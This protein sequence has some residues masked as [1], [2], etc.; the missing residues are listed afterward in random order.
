MM[1]FE[2]QNRP[3]REQHKNEFWT[4]S[5]SEVNITN[6][7]EKVDQKNGVICLVSMLSS[8]VMVLKLSKK[9]LFCNFMLTSAR[10]LSWLKQFTYMHLKGLVTHFQKLM[11]FIMLWLTVSVVWVFEVVEFLRNFWWVSIFF[12]ILIAKISWT[13][14]Q[15]PINHSIFWKS[16]MRTFRCIYVNCFNRL[17]FFA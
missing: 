2:D 13:A 11:L 4:F 6:K 10:N 7:L 15:T 3:T 16:V 17:K 8:W 14:V 5:N 12:N 1:Y 9:W